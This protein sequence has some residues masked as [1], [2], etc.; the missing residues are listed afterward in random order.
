MITG[1]ILTGLIVDLGGGP[2]HDRIGFRYWKNPGAL[3]Q[4][5]L[6]SENK[7]GLGRFL[8]LLSVLVQAAFSFQGMELVAIAASETESGTLLNVVESW[9]VPVLIRPAVLPSPLVPLHLRLAGTAATVLHPP[10]VMS[11]PPLSPRTPQR[12]TQSSPWA[13]PTCLLGQ[14]TLKLLPWP[15]NTLHK[16]RIPSTALTGTRLYLG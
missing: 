15:T 12:V 1:L 14:S 7:V 2:D 10:I 13:L 11:L 5:D 3:A 6:V 9:L 16:P 4:S 8:G